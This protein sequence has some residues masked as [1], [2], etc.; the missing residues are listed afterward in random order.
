MQLM[1]YLNI[2]YDNIHSNHKSIDLINISHFYLLGADTL[3]ILL[4]NGGSSLH[5]YKLLN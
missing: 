2:N 3:L 4:V 1:I 5:T